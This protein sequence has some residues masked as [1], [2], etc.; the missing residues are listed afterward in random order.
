MNVSGPLHELKKKI[1]IKQ[2]PNLVEKSTLGF[3]FMHMVNKGK[4]LCLL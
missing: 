1:D 3:L 4:L 2:R